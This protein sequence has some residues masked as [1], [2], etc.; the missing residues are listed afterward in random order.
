MPEASSKTSKV[1]DGKQY[2]DLGVPQQLLLRL[3]VGPG[4][5]FQSGVFQSS[6]PCGQVVFFAE[7][8]F[9]PFWCYNSS[10]IS[11]V[12]SSLEE[13]YLVLGLQWWDECFPTCKMLGWH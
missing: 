9:L 7:G 11:M 4:E 1:A 2:P 12:Q 8:G 10:S 3:Q 13:L 6:L 5:T